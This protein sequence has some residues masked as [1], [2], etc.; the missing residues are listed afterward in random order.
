MYVW[1]CVVQS[2]FCAKAEV[3][4]SSFKNANELDVWKY[5][6]LMLMK[7]KWMFIFH[8]ANMKIKGHAGWQQNRQLGIFLKQKKG[9]SIL[10][11]R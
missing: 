10:V 2:T 1:V 3:Y 7:M 8:S 11:I 6:R 4:V 9:Q 5:N